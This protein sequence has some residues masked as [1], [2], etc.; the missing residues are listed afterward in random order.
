[1]VATH[2]S[3]P[4]HIEQRIGSFLRGRLRMARAIYQMAIAE[5]ARPVDAVRMV[6]AQMDEVPW[7]VGEIVHLG[8]KADRWVTTKTVQAVRARMNEPAVRATVA[9]A[10]RDT[11]R[12][13]PAE[14]RGGER[15]KDADD[16]TINGTTFKGRGRGRVVVLADTRKL[17]DR[18]EQSEGSMAP[19][20]HNSRAL[21]FGDRVDVN[22][23]VPMLQM[24]DLDDWKQGHKL[25]ALADRG[26]GVVPVSV[27]EIS[28]A[29][30]RKAYEAS[31]PSRD[32]LQQGAGRT[33]VDAASW[34]E[35]IIGRGRAIERDYL[36]GVD[37][38]V[39][40][41][42]RMGQ[43]SRELGRVL[44]RQFGMA[45]SRARFVARDRLGSLHASISRERHRR[46]GFQAYRWLSA[47]DSRVRPLHAELHNTV[48]LWTDPHPTD[49]HPGDAPNCRCVAVPV[50]IDEY[51]EEA[52]RGRAAVAAA[53]GVAVGVALAVG[54][55]RTRRGVRVRPSEVPFTRP[56]PRRGRPGLP[57]REAEV[58]PFPSTVPLPVAPRVDPRPIREAARAMV[59]NRMAAVLQFPGAGT[60]QRLRR[61][62]AARW[63]FAHDLTRRIRAAER[64]AGQEVS[65][66]S[67]TWMLAERAIRQADT[68]AELMARLARLA[69][70]ADR[71]P[72]RIGRQ[73]GRPAPRRIE[74]KRRRQS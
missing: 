46:L 74:R 23:P 47:D 39:R 20:D 11:T 9:N 16:V 8:E 42:A 3:Y 30:F 55:R 56:R 25:R 48:R 43:G 5:G 71:P 27:P 49:G 45:E 4:L 6:R 72:T 19:G 1:M 57:Q 38:A 69:G 64:A 32:A 73:R 17:R 13:V 54:L 29:A 65:S 58:V 22:T 28:A 52:R 12:Y 34:A 15:R 26:F 37:E 44:R 53:V 21:A 2:P 31:A 67:A 62:I 51:R 36:G 66:Y 50:T 70:R 59:S 61:N 35:G 24:G 41:A 63:K 68:D 60:G 7:D 14:P 33:M 10:D 40:A 18:Y